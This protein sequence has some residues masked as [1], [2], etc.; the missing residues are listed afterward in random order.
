MLRL[1]SEI[2]EHQLDREAIRERRRQLAHDDP[3]DE[4]PAGALQPPTPPPRPRTA[5]FRRPDRLASL[6]LSFRT[7]EQPKRAEVIRAL[8]TILDEL[9]SGPAGDPEA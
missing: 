3:S 4:A 7:S 1:V 6:S 5:R 9:R 2:A 8:E